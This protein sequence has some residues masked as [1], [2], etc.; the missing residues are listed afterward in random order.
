MNNSE[1]EEKYKAFLSSL[2][3]ELMEE[4]LMETEGMEEEK[5]PVF[6]KVILKP[7]MNVVFP[8]KQLLK[9]SEEGTIRRLY[10]YATP[11]ISIAA[12]L[13]IGLIMQSQ[14]PKG[15]SS[16]RLSPEQEKV[17]PNFPVMEAPLNVQ[18]ENNNIPV[19]IYNAK[20][21]MLNSISSVNGH[22]VNIKLDPAMESSSRE[23]LQNALRLLKNQTPGYTSAS[24]AAPATD[25]Y[26]SS[27]I[28]RHRSGFEQAEARL[29]LSDPLGKSTSLQAKDLN[30][31]NFNNLNQE[32]MYSVRLS[33][34]W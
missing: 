10:R 22:P 14:L 32:N 31:H 16:S 24:L 15:D 28:F 13:L 18:L 7:D 5:L 8:N 19:H 2:Y 27:L 6:E 11:A 25:E 26:I 29:L 21:E 17:L 33:L 1:R 23:Q 9:K 4:E 30:R 34:K 12:L 3:D 20:G